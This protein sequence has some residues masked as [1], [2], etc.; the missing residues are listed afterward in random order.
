MLTIAL[1][2]AWGHT[3]RLA[4]TGLA[5]VLGV[6]FLTGTL[7]LGDT[8]RAN[9]DDL[10]SETTAGIDVI[11]RN[12]TT[13]SRGPAQSEERSFVDA[14]LVQTVARVDGVARAEPQIEGYAAILGPDGEAVG[15]N[16]PPRLA[17][18]WID[19]PD[20]TP[21]RLA[22]GR[23]PESDD[24]VVINRGAARDAD[25]DV[26]DSA[27]VLVPGPVRVTVVGIA[28]FGDEDGLGETTFTAFTLAAAQQHIAGGR[29]LVS[30]VAA[31]AEPGVSQDELADRIEP[32]VPAGA[33]A[34]TGAELTD[35]QVDDI[36]SD[37]LGMLTTFLTVFAGIALLVATFSIYN[38]FS[39]LVAQR[40]R[41]M[42]LLR[43]VGA[44]RRQ[45]LTAV[46]IEALA[47]GIVGSLVGLAAGLGVAGLLKGLF[48]AVGGALP[49]GGT[50]VTVS[51]VVIGLAVGVLATLAAAAGP[52]VRASRIAP[53][54]ALREAA[55]DRAG[56]SRAR[57][58]AGVLA[59]G[60]GITAVLVGALVGGD[61]L[62]PVAGVGAVA[63]LV[64]VVVAGPVAARPAVA[65]LGAPLSR[66]RR[67]SGLLAQR[68]AMRNPRRTAATASALLV[69]VG[70]VTVFTVFAASLQASLDRTIDRTF[71][72]DLVVAAPPF[73]G[74]GIDPQLAPALDDVPEVAGTVGLGAGG[75][76]V[77]GR[78]RPIA[79][80]DP[81]A[82]GRVLDIDVTAGSVADVG[83]DG[84]AVAASTAEDRGWA[85]GDAVPVTWGDGSEQELTIRALYE[86][87]DIVGGVLIPRAAYGPHTTQQIDTAVFVEVAD[88]VSIDEAKAAVAP[89]LERYGASDPQDRE[90][91]AASLTEGL[92]MLLT[93]VYALLALAIIIALMG[94][95]NTLALST[96]ERR[97]ELGLL[98]AVGQ[99]R[100]QLRAMVRQE[101]VLIAVF[102][103]VG[104]LGLGVFLGWGM[105]EAVGSTSGA[106]SAFALPVARLA[107]V[108]VVG[109][110]AGVLAGVRPARRAARLD[111][112]A[113]VA[114]D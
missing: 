24:E 47:V 41:E 82:L 6:A 59:L 84:M 71:G 33:E 40:T 114:G 97:R 55:V 79:V 11:V 49:A 23:A 64:G 58:V 22:E 7:V 20:L 65:V 73:G 35:E 54:A 67:S 56:T 45:V 25:L 19:D 5:V 66:W 50:V 36:E 34:I 9:F 29:D 69:G 80:A 89:V 4:G 8:L 95:A 15:G 13:L 31:E 18:N 77:D 62:L 106:T 105:V 52:A 37:F 72:A 109:A 43:A 51:T 87:A 99:T 107:V 74:A 78:E 75:A 100:R 12:P 113:A 81:A 86:E 1:K 85:L 76:V 44:A 46:A 93:V 101:S 42:A 27:T 48:D 90:E 91:Y 96:W 94:I 2:S 111:V 70:V 104:G 98:R 3:G 10:F 110:I 88:G 61:A 83:D 57:V 53:L 112:L 16:G 92:D 68:N 108:L 63:T 32:I 102:G 26:G 103:T 38:T 28:T 17:G 39:I 21:Y 60:A 14:G 30:A